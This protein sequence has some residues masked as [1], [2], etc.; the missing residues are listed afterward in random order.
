MVPN[1]DAVSA[2]E[3]ADSATG[4]ATW[5]P[6]QEALE[7]L[8]RN[9]PKAALS[10][11]M[12]AYGQGVYRFIRQI[13]R[14]ESMAEDLQQLTFVQAFEGFTRFNRRSSLRTWLLSIARHRSLDSLKSARRRRKRFLESEELPEAPAQEVRAD[15]RLEEQ[16]WAQAL[17]SCVQRLAPEA[18]TAVLLRFQQSL[19]Y[20]QIA[21]M[22]GEEAG[23]LRVR[24]SRAL[25]KLRQ[26]L[27]G[28]GMT[29]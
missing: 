8:D 2:K 3:D 13:V 10:I 5:D 19:P 16:S 9:D 12:E 6:E 22:C 15:D 18:R 14:D 29:R 26:C 24:V 4:Q 28:L 11:L 20:S 23:T 21:R 25:P 17:E 1:S 7:A 27:E